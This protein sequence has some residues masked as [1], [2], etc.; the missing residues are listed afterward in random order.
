MT[1][2]D[3]ETVAAWRAGV[4]DSPAGPLFANRYTE[5]ELVLLDIIDTRCADCTGSYTIQCR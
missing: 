3:L 4:E 5:S 2:T 1:E